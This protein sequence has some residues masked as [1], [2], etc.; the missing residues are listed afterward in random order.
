MR[1]A[2]MRRL[3]MRLD[4]RPWLRSAQL[5][6]MA[7]VLALASPALA[8]EDEDDMAGPAQGTATAVMHDL[9]GQDVG[10]VTLLQTPTGVL[11]TAR[12][13]D[14]PPG[15]H[16]FHI[17]EKGVCEPP[18]KSAGGHFN[19]DAAAHGYLNENGPHAGD[20]PNIHVPDSGTL[21]VEMHDPLISLRG[22]EAVLDADGA[23]IVIHDGPD[24]YK[25]QPAG[26]AGARIACG[27]IK[28]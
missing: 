20:L 6:V 26:D 13:H 16:G 2:E 19:P 15:I 10:T 3:E 12:L 4:R 22:E 9:K 11:I 27:V 17:H 18:F 1:S 28:G 23:A 25:S 24:D 21:T 14:L 5:A 7:G 8:Q